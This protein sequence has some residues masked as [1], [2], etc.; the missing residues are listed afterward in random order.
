MPEAVL[1][2]GLLQALHIYCEKMSIASG[3]RIYFQHFGAAMPRDA[4]LELSV[5]RIIQEL[6]QNAL[7]HAHCRQILVE[8][9]I[10]QHLLS[11]D[12]DDD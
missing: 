8:L 6:I 5:Y 9:N 11:I 10:E 3:A 2:G 1:Q 7:K 12:V 4:D